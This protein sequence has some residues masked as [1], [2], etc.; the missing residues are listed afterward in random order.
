MDSA[1]SEEVTRQ[2]W[3]ANQLPYGAARTAATEAIARRVE[4]DG[5]PELLPRALL[6]LVTS[7]EFGSDRSKIYVPL[8]RLLR[9]WDTN[10]E[11]FHED[12]LRY[13]LWDYKWG[14]EAL[15][16][17]PEITTA[18]AEEFL[19]E[20]GRRFD[21]AGFGR[22]AVAHKQ[23]TWAWATGSPDADEAMRAWLALPEDDIDDC[24][25]CRIGSQVAYL[26]EVGRYEDVIS[27]LARLWSAGQQYKCV[28]EPAGMFSAVALASLEIGDLAGAAAAYRQVLA[29][30]DPSRHE[31]AAVFG[32]EFELL[33][34]GG[35]IDRAL[36]RLRNIYPHLLDKASTPLTRLNFL[37]SVAAGLSANLDQPELPTGLTA[38]SQRTL[39]GLHGWVTVAAR[40][41]AARF[42]ERNGNDYYSR[43]LAKS[44]DAVRAAEK[45]DL[46]AEPSKSVTAVEPR[47]YLAPEAGAPQDAFGQADL[48]LAA[49]DLAAAAQL[50][51]RAA[52]PAEA[53]GRLGDAGLAWAESARC[54]AEFGDDATAHER[55]GLAL[56]R[57]RAADASVALLTEVLLAWAPV[58]A[59]IGDLVPV[60]DAIDD[61]LVRL[62]KEEVSEVSEEL[63][64]KRHYELVRMHASLQDAQ[65]RAVA[66]LADEQ[67]A[68][69]RELRDA[70]QLA[71]EAAEEFA[72]ADAVADAA[73]SYWL[74]GRLWRDTGNSEEALP[75]Y[76]LAVEGFGLAHDGRLRAEAAGEYIELLRAS[77]RYAKADEVV[78]RL[79]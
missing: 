34:R 78:A 58:A 16:D 50:Y 71:T 79:F 75:V 76:E 46:D 17:F 9:L 51:A 47:T 35:H 28:T 1:R 29:T 53:D 42:D 70:I 22:G 39:A 44:L 20:M 61:A 24:E 66:S 62:D 48:L 64:D 38:E 26:A 77:G 57:L 67:R 63:A 41:L 23:F 55:F 65:A 6:E 3:A 68:P 74:A 4:A 32:R 12:D 73:H 36:S 5:P 18:Q 40:A 52:E 69:G 2:L 54:A 7:Y 11:F 72:H 27:G 45:L 59:R 25:A 56:P 49:G 13:L 30:L 10:P 43:R 21:I 14:A 15:G 31:Y 37:L 19:T 8:A 33:A 60:M